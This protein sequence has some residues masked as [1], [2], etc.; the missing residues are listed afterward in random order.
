MGKKQELEKILEEY[1]LQLAKEGKTQKEIEKLA[2]ISAKT[3]RKILKKHG[4]NSGVSDKQ[5]DYL[6]A[7][8]STHFEV[9]DLI[10]LRQKLKG[11]SQNQVKGMFIT[12]RQYQKIK[13]SL[14]YYE[15]MLDLKLKI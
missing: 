6:L 14:K 4:V 8:V 5:I 7:L 12:L 1:V 2:G 15:K 11:L 10:S 9:K 13:P 3:I